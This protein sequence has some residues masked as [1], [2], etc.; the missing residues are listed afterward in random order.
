[1][2]VQRLGC[3]YV[4]LVGDVRCVCRVFHNSQS[5]PDEPPAFTGAC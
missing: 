4:F 2:V 3:L 1:M 5:N